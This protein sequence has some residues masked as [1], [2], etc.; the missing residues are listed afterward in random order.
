MQDLRQK[1]P[2][3]WMIYRFFKGFLTNKYIT[4]S[5]FQPA[6]GLRFLPEE[7]PCLAFKCF[8]T[9]LV[10]RYQYG[11]ASKHYPSFEPQIGFIYHG[12]FQL[13][14]KQWGNHVCKTRL[15]GKEPSSYRTPKH[16][17]VKET[18]FLGQWA[19]KVLTEKEGRGW[20]CQPWYSLAIFS[21][22]HLKNKNCMSLP[23][24]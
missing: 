4:P 18:G 13:D 3:R 16:R 10:L 24:T 22:I 8:S 23:L 5:S 12:A 11:S 19:S 1:L 21:L 14:S 6:T 7:K 15:Q 9:R 20:I 17:K 2:V